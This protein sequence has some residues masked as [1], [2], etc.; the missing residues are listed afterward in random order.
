MKARALPRRLVAL[1]AWLV[2]ACSAVTAQESDLTIDAAIGFGGVFRAGT[3]TPVYITASNIG[4]NFDGIIRVQVQRGARFGDQRTTVTYE[5]EMELVSGGSKAYSFVLPLSTTVYPIR[6]T[7]VEDGEVRFREDV[8]LAGKSVPGTLMLALSRRPTLDFLLPLYNSEN[9][10]SLDIAYPLSV[11][12]P[13]QWHGYDGV[14]LV[15]VHDARLSELT[16]NQITALRDW[17]AAGGRLVI[18]AGTHYGPADGEALAPF[19]AFAPRELGVGAVQESGLLEVGLP[20]APEERRTDVALTTFERDRQGVQRIPFGLGDIILLPFDYASF[21]RVAPRTSVALWNSIMQAGS[22]LDGLPTELRRRVFEIDLLANQLQLPVYEFP[23]RFL[24][25]GLFASYLVASVFLLYWLK[26]SRSAVRRWFGMPTLVAAVVAVSIAGHGALTVT[27]QPDETLFLSIEQAVLDGSQEYATVTRDSVVF[28]RRSE[29]YEISH[30]GYPLVIPLDEHDQV[31]ARGPDSLSTRVATE[32][33]GHRNAVAMNVVPLSVTF[34][35]A[36]GERY[37]TFTIHNRSEHT[38][39]ES[40]I[41]AH[42]YPHRAGTLPPGAE[43]EV[44][45]QLERNR[46]FDEI[47]WQ[48]YV[49]KD[50]LA[51][52]RARLLGD[53]AR[54]QR[55]DNEDAP[56]AVLIAWPDEPLLPVEVSPD[57]YQDVRMNVLTMPLMLDRPVRGD[58]P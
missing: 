14:D 49:P 51:V 58:A 38:L 20:I 15:V 10:R 30:P 26:S 1:L 28:A 27:M 9:E 46:S 16:E 56:D 44:T 18:S 32:R 3:W 45:Q 33:W 2:I 31:I 19:G 39:T 24:V 57:F 48:S 4:Q 54:R 34:R 25:G 36:A 40:L 42:G 22:S 11:F 7:A 6:I 47:D 29:T 52:H 37:N 13:D 23:S 21:V 35:G 43:L 41:L 5:R 17:T 12:L 8:E 55:F 53:L 50:R